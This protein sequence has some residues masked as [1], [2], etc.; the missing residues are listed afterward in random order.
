MAEKVLAQYQSLVDDY[1][2]M[3]DCLEQS[4][5]AVEVSNETTP[6]TIL[7]MK[8]EGGISSTILSAILTFYVT[9]ASQ[10][11]G[12]IGTVLSGLSG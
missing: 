7:G 6:F 2:E 4:L 12:K 10:I 11:S 3:S 1:D 8:A 9:L 5:A